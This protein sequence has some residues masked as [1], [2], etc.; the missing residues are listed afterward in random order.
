M[1]VDGISLLANQDLKFV[2]VSFVVLFWN[3]L[4]VAGVSIHVFM[5]FPPFFLCGSCVCRVSF[6]S[7][8]TSDLMLCRQPILHTRQITSSL[9]VFSHSSCCSD[10][11]H[12]CLITY[13]HSLCLP[14]WLVHIF[15]LPDPVSCHFCSFW[16]LGV[17]VA[18][19]LLTGC[20]FAKI[21]V[22]YASAPRVSPHSAPSPVVFSARLWQQQF[23]QFWNLRL[24]S[25]RSAVSAQSDASIYVE[26]CFQPC[27]K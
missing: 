27:V 22:D 14:C 6:R 24:C 1:K 17:S 19:F 5:V 18:T 16:F 10:W 8:C 21:T 7:V 25:R 20:F 15:D 2:F 26:L 11:I 13:A 9:C 23:P 3:D 4:P 12:L